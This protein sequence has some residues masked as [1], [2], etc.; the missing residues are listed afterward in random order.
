MKNLVALFGTMII[1]GSLA[2]AKIDDARFGLYTGSRYSPDDK[3]F[4]TQRQA[5]AL[6]VNF[7]HFTYYLRFIPSVIGSENIEMEYLKEFMDSALAVS[8]IPVIICNPDSGIDFFSDGTA[9][10]SMTFFADWLK[11]FPGK[12]II[13]FGPEM[14]GGWHGPWGQQG[15]NYIAAFRN[16]ADVLRQNNSDI[17]MAWVPNWGKGY[18]WGNTSLDPGGVYSD[19]FPGDNYVDYVGLNCYYRDWECLDY[20]PDWFFLSVMNIGNFYNQYATS[21]HPMII[22]ESSAFDPHNNSS[23]SSTRVPLTIEEQLVFKKQYLRSAV[24]TINNYPL[25][26]TL[27]IF[28]V[29]KDEG[30]ADSL[31]QNLGQ[32]AFD[33]RLPIDYL[34]HLLDSVNTGV[35]ENIEK[36]SLA[37]AYPNPCREQLN[38]ANLTINQAV[39]VILTNISGQII[40]ETSYFDNAVSINTSTLAPGIYFCQIISGNKREVIKIIHF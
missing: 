33:F 1:L 10:S 34:R 20:V 37:A 21:K 32:V 24:K 3:T 12:I 36:N 23:G 38:F 16:V 28:Y 31:H 17:K 22:T 18:P 26:E 29:V 14:N 8:G 30:A 39:K 7:S 15:T 5:K 9:N 4:I 13:S 6:G 19:Y 27:C 2:F 11:Q 25:L 40:N 35:E